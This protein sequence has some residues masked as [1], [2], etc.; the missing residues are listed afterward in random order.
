MAAVCAIALSASAATA[1]AA[2][3][4]FKYT[5]QV[6][7]VSGTP[8]NLFGGPIAVGDTLNGY[9]SWDT[10]APDAFPSDPVFGRYVFDGGP[11]VIGLLTPTVVSAKK[12][13]INL[14]NGYPGPSDTLTLT[15]SEIDGL[16]T[17]IIIFG[18]GAP[19]GGLWTTDALPSTGLS[20][21]TLAAINTSF[22]IMAGNDSLSAKIKTFEVGSWD[23]QPTPDPTPTVP[24]PTSL[25]MLGSGLLGLA[26]RA[27]RLLRA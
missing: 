7:N 15:A 18:F 20:A 5:V 2:I 25:V 3:V 13:G 6:T 10:S 26:T 22:T 9:L 8:S 23:P 19:A 1:Q 16:G 14:S 21:A 11:S 27:R 17:G 24:E 12:F 4:D